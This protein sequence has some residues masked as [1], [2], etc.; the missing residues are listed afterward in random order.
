M[1]RQALLVIS[2]CIVGVPT[3]Q[4][5]GA[6]PR[7]AALKQ[8]ANLIN[9]WTAAV[10]LLFFFSSSLL[11][12]LPSSSHNPPALSRISHQTLS[13]VSVR[14]YWSSAILSLS[15]L[16]HTTY[17]SGTRFLLQIGN[18]HNSLNCCSLLLS[19]STQRERFSLDTFFYLLRTL[20]S[21]IYRIDR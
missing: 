13:L 20:S 4:A 6:V 12:L 16:S 7:P 19:H 2:V 5:V 21:S 15:L 17:L 3:T 9:N 10:L 8:K 14:L 1:Y 18:P 11:P